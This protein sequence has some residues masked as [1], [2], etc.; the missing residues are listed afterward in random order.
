MVQ[1][2]LALLP[3]PILVQC[4]HTLFASDECD[5]VDFMDMQAFVRHIHQAEVL[6][7]HAGAGSILNA[8]RAN[9]RPIVMARRAIFNEVINDHQVTF[10]KVLQESGKVLVIENAND[11]KI[12][13]EKLKEKSSPSND[14]VSNACHTIKKRIEQIFS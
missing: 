11:L 4:G 14:P 3:K 10:A 6:I 5:V 2:Q 9:Q 12:N 1:D 7:L 8:L 13:L